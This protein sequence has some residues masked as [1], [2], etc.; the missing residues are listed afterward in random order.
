MVRK[1][2]KEQ[3]KQG[4]VWYLLVHLSYYAEHE[5]EIL[6]HRAAKKAFNDLGLKKLP[7]VK[8][9][10][11]EYAALLAEKRAAY[12]S[13]REARAEMKKLLTCRANAEAILCGKKCIAN[14]SSK[15][16]HR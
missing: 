5:Q 6:L 10:Q 7:T 16:G 14:T 3:I 9:L 1:S 12:P 11:A 4:L 15:Y 8:A 13:Y 2:P